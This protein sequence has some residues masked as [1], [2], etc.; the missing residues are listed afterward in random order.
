MFLSIAQGIQVGMKS[1]HGTLNNE[2]G[3]LNLEPAEA[4]VTVIHK[5]RSLCSLAEG[6]LIGSLGLSHGFYVGFTWL[7]RVR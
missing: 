3:T 7:Y 2:P 1:E 6:L 4:R 5:F